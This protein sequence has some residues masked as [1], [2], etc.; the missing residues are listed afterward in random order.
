MEVLTKHI[1]FLC[2]VVDRRQVCNVY[3][4]CMFLFDMYVCK[5]ECV[6]M[7]VQNF[8]HEFLAVISMGYV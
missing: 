1:Y 5:C 6:C 3:I 8:I 2:N 4:L 7:C